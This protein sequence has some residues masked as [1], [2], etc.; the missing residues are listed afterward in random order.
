MDKSA[1]TKN[2]F[3]TISFIRN[4]FLLRSN[5]QKKNNSFFFF[6]D[7]VTTFYTYDRKKNFRI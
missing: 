6:A 3:N 5:E 4:L 7:L 2:D 1:I